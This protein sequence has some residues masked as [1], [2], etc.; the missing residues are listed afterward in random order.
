MKTVIVNWCSTLLKLYGLSY[1]TL[2]LYACLAGILMEWW[3][4]AGQKM[5]L[6]ARI[7]KAVG[8][9]L[10]YIA[11]RFAYA[12]YQYPS[13]LGWIVFNIILAYIVQKYACMYIVKPIRKTYLFQ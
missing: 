6:D 12:T 8:L 3:K 5:D 9:L 4:K 2:A 13:G 10:S 11:V 7:Y 1:L